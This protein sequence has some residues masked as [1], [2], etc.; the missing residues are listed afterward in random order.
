MKFGLDFGTTNSSL[1]LLADGKVKLLPVDQFAPEPEVVRSAVYFYPRKLVVSK[2]ATKAQIQSQTFNA[3]QI[4]YEG[5]VKTL[6][7][8]QAVKTYLEDNKFRKPGIKR[9]IYSGRT[10]RVILWTNP[11][12]GRVYTEDVPE[13]LEEIDYGT[14]RLFHAL[15]TALKS[16]YYKG[17][18]V[19][20]NF[21]SLEE[22]IG[23]FVHEIKKKAE[24]SIGTDIKEITV[25]RPVYFSDEPEKDKAAQERLEN[26]IKNAGIKKVNF[27]FEP[28]G[29]AKY[30]LHKNPSFQGKVLVFDFGGG[31]LDTT[32]IER[33]GS[34]YQ[35][36]TTDGV[37]IGGDLLNSDIFVN[38]LGKHFGSEVHWGEK[39]LGI[40]SRFMDALGSWF[41]IPNLNNSED[42]EILQRVKDQSDDPRAIESLIYLVKSNLGFEIYET[43]ENAKKQLSFEQETILAYRDGPIDFSEKITRKEFETLIK[44][45]I[46]EVKKTVIRTMRKIHTE[47]EDIKIV[48]AT[49]G[50]S[51]LP[52]VKRTLT[53]IFGGGKVQFFD[54]FTS[55][56][57]GLVL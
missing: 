31:T 20:G 5:K 49:G 52:V 43:I 35:V 55:I 41:S 38:K 19:F 30:F 22:L 16:P 36:L 4:S 39:Q 57:G 24:D 25:G 40:P 14:G 46:N 27:E 28:V 56:A 47:P 15:K 21:Y 45:R 48:V 53:D 34:K 7:G 13:V 12:S 3:N 18:A 42:M 6:F 1:S 29:A 26:A 10:I 32:I 23:L 44:P 2:T 50:S 37:Y 9:R 51:L 8:I 33:R 54:L 17:S 11:Y